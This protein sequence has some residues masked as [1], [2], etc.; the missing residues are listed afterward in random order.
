MDKASED[1][2]VSSK[3]L[4]FLFFRHSF[5]SL[6]KLH[7][8]INDYKACF[9]FLDLAYLPVLTI[10]KKPVDTKLIEVLQLIE[11]A[12]DLLNLVFVE[13]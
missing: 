9:F 1:V 3:G 5:K 11:L 12:W 10:V 6:K 8:L 13:E 7:E 4:Y 2:M